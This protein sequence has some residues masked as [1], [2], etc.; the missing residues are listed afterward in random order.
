LIQHQTGWSKQDF[1]ELYDYRD[2]FLFLVWRDIKVRYAQTVLGFLWAILQPVIQILIFTIVFGKVAKVPTEGLPYVL[3][4]SVAIIPWT[5]ISQAMTQSCLSMVSNQTMLGKIYFPRLLFPIT[6]VLAYLLDFF[7][8]MLIIACAMLY[9]QVRPTWNLLYFPL[10]V[11]MMVGIT[12]AVG[13]WMSTLAIRFRDVKHALPFTIR[14][15]MYTAPIVYSA[16]T[17]PAHWRLAY[18]INPVV[19]VI[20]GFRACFTGVPM[21][22]QFIWPGMVS[23][24]V[25]LAVGLWYF[26]HMEGVFADVI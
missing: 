5:Y 19:G 23:T 16:S 14:M 18:C 20:E 1:R 9:Y 12:A 13:I 21:P 24:I 10:F 2:L 3:F 4:S 8:S 11:I 25:L 6:P 15:L 17:I 7:I 26:K 22:W